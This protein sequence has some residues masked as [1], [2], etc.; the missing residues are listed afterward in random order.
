MI[1]ECR[2][3][4]RIVDDLKDVSVIGLNYLTQNRIMSRM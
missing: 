1:F 3:A 2:R 4:E